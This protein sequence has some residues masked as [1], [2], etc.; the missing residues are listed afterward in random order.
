MAVKSIVAA[1]KNAF[2]QFVRCIL[3]SVFIE[4]FMNHTHT[5]ATI[6]VSFSSRS[7]FAMQAARHHQEK[8]KANMKYEKWF[9]FEFHFSRDWQISKCHSISCCIVI[10]FDVFFVNAID[11]DKIK[12]W[13]LYFSTVN[14]FLVMVLIPPREFRYLQ[15]NCYVSSLYFYTNKMMTIDTE[16]W[17]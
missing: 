5:H 17:R 6:I 1:M 15:T 9:A 8:Q 12:L 11:M 7:I 10:S 4:I 2:T 14:F 3:F 16:A 13:F